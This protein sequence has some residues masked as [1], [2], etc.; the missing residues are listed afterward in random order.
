MQLKFNNL[1]PIVVAG[2][3]AFG[4]NS[5]LYGDLDQYSKINTIA[6]NV[7][8]SSYLKS[9]D[10]GRDS[11]LFLKSMFQ[12]FADKWRSNTMFSSSV[13]H[14]IDDSNFKNIVA[15]GKPAVPFIVADICEKP[16]LLVWALNL[17]YGTK[18]S[19]EPNVTIEQAC[20]LWVRHLV[21]Q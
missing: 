10:G 7:H 3:F 14:I 13:Q 6:A 4:G 20:K 1:N 18:I 2:V 9:I 8:T 5:F 17:I 12:D 19:E 16:S 11:Q 21:Q 15:M